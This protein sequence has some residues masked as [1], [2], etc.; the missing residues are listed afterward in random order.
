M[1]GGGVMVRTPIA[2]FRGKYSDATADK[3]SPGGQGETNG[4]FFRT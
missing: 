1:F 3:P 2:E 4:D